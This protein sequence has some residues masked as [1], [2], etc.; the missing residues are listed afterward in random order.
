M[1]ALVCGLILA[2]SASAAGDEGP[3]FA[4][5]QGGKWGYV[6][7]TGQIVIPP[8]F[9]LAG[10]FSEGL[11][12][13][14]LG[15]TL[16]YVDRTGEIV[17]VPEYAPTATLYLPFS[18][19]LAPVRA[20]DLY[21]YID[22]SG[23]LAIPARYIGAEEF[24]EGYAMACLPTG[25]GYID[26]QGRGVIAPEFMASR[27]VRGGVACANLAMAMGRERVVLFTAK[28][29]RLPGEFD[30]CG[31]ASDGLVAVKLRGLWGYVDASGT[32]I[33]ARRFAWAGEFVAGLAP[34]RAYEADLCG[35]IDRTGAFAIPAAYRE[36]APF[37][38]GLARVDL[39]Q[40]RTDAGRIAFIDR[41]GKAVI[42]GAELRP[43][44][45]AAEDFRDGLAAVAV[46]GAPHAAGPGGP[47]LGYVD[48]AGRWIWK[49]TR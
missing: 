11:A 32:P 14:K 4:I 21:G 44:F 49:P 36:C 19:G 10:R 5:V 41:T 15:Q 37:V 7:R 9:D 34:A 45:D 38:D 2:T 3:L 16:G 35:Y 1:R 42:V 47:R 6:D 20:G 40:S 13:V 48:T 28:G 43:S 17:L 39:A 18:S 23:K 26:P 8:R 12:P 46:G 29:R 25:C 31:N 24:S 27:P 30:G 22:R 33:V